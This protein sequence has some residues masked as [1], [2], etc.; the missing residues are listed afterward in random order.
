MKRFIVALLLAACGIAA[1]QT[2]APKP[3]PEQSQDATQL[4]TMGSDKGLSPTY[5]DTYCAGFVTKEKYD[6]SNYVKGD[7]APDISRTAAR[8]IVFLSGTGYTVGSRY[9]VVRL[10]KDANKFEIFPGQ[11]AMLNHMG[12]LYADIGRVRVTRLENNIAVADVEFSCEPLVIGDT[13]IPFAP[14]PRPA[15]R[16]EKVTFQRFA[17]F[18]GAPSGRIIMGKGFEDFVGTGQKVYI[19]IGSEK[20]LKPGDYLR[21]TRGYDPKGMPPV[22]KLSMQAPYSEDSQKNPK[23]TKPSGGKSTPWR[24]VG[25]LMVLSTTPTTAT[26]IITT[27]LEDIHL[28]DVVETQSK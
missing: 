5:S 8:G 24:G 12:N 3:E 6:P 17:D 20:G 19:N 27:A 1:A 28:G 23:H 10:S 7:I 16:T 22:E 4:S 21:I 18:D 26:G 15:Y 11:N 25:E 13:V 2:Q 9:S 14:R